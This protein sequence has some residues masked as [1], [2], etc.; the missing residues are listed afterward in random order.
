MGVRGIGSSTEEAFE[1]AAL[2]LSELTTECDS[3]SQTEEVEIRCDAPDVEVLL[4][5]WLNAIIFEMATRNMVFGAFRVSIDDGRLIGTAAGEKR[6]AKRH[7]AGVEVKGATFTEL[8]VAQLDDGS[9][10]AQCVVDV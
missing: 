7:T 3:V 2:G 10:L 4:V 9:W 8:R 1:C 6:D 5:D